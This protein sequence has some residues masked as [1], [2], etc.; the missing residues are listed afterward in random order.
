MLDRHYDAKQYASR[1]R[2]QCKRDII[3][4]RKKNRKF[5]EKWCDATKQIERTI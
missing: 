3:F 1:F 2:I 4:F 5:V